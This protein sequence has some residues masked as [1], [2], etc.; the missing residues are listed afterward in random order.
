MPAPRVYVVEITDIEPDIVVG[1]IVRSFR[2]MQVND[3]LMPYI[4]QQSKITLTESKK[5]LDGKIIASEEKATLFGYTDIAFIDKGN[6]DGVVPGQKYSIYHQEK[7][8]IDPKARKYT[9]LPIINFGTLLVLH[10]EETTSTVLI[11]RSDRDIA[12]GANI[13]TLLK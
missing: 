5:G 3:F 11:T 7:E 6:N 8:R 2:D 10:T 4:P 9:L 13:C 1:T 12:P